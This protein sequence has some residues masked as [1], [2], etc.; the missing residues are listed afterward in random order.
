MNWSEERYTF[1]K[2]LLMFSQTEFSNDGIVHWKKLE[3]EN[4][5][6]YRVMMVAI[7]YN[8]LYSR[9]FNPARRELYFWSPQS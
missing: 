5:Y 7:L 2:H 6:P 3:Q 1:T 4:K 8:I 9:S